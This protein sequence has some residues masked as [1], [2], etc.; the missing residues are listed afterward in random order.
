MIRYVGY[1]LGIE[2][3]IALPLPPIRSM[4]ALPVI[5]VQVGGF[6]APEMLNLP[7]VTG[8]AAFGPYSGGVLIRTEGL[9]DFLV[10]KSRILIGGPRAEAEV[11]DIVVRMV[12]GFVLQMR[13]ILAFHGA[14]V[15]RNGRAIALFG[16]SG[17]GKS[18]AAMGL[19]R[20]GWGFLCD[21]IVAIES[22]RRVPAG[23][24][25]A[26]LN[27]DSFDRLSKGLR[28]AP[29]SMD[30]DGKYSVKPGSEGRAAALDSVFVIEAA[31]VEAVESRAVR[32]YAKLRIVLA[33]MHS[34]SGIGD[35]GT[36]LRKAAEVL[37]RVS[38]FVIKRPS[39]RFALDDLLDTI[40]ALSLRED[41]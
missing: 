15:S 37:E 1:G 4:A 26:R 6:D 21:D 27:S 16:D 17:A 33:H 11:G 9:P 32:G 30:R 12:L 23:A 13:S 40:E 24:T 14:A 8:A 22:G 7:Y 28:S 20:R 39:S 3:E 5:A 41:P 29:S 2:S 19:A 36:R 34:L 38:L 35:P 31:E 10:S 25:R 18:T